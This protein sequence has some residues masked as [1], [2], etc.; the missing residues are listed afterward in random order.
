MTCCPDRWRYAYAMDDNE[1]S[2]NLVDHPGSRIAKSGTLE[3]SIGRQVRNFRKRLDMTVTELARQAGLSSGMLSKIENGVTSPSL[4]TLQSL[5]EALNVPV[6]ALFRQYEEQRDATFV[7]S[8]E[9]LK[10][11]RRGTRSGHQYRLLGHSFS[12]DVTMEPYVVTLTEESEVFP[13][14]Q[15]QG[16]ELIYMLEGEMDYQH[17]G[18]SYRLAPGDSLFFDGNA[19][20]G[21][22]MLVKSPISFVCVIAH[23]HAGDD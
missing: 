9:G 12:K 3:G 19:P 21:P 20:H 10:I 8:G 17:G 7:R 11:D 14:F 6:T 5:S 16:N 15:H 22:Q 4:A 18:A 1:T 13:L 2:D 23:P